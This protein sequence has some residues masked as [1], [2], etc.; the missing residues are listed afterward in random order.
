MNETYIRVVVKG[1]L[2]DDELLGLAETLQNVADDV[3][4]SIQSDFSRAIREEV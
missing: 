1:E 2:T 4:E 3:V